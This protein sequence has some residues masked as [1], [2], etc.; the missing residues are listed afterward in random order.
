MSDSIVRLM[1]YDPRWRQEFQQTRSSILFSCQGWVT[2]VEHIGS[3][4]IP[5][6]VAR[7]IIDCIAGVSDSA[8]FESASLLIEGM[9]FRRIDVPKWADECWVLAK[10]RHGETSHL[11]VLAVQDS[12]VWQRAVAVRDYLRARPEEAIRFEETKIRRWRNHEGDPAQYQRDKS[13]FFSH[14]LDQIE[15]TGST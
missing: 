6:L 1:H 9:N 15:S 11:V 12:L 14:L 10:P 3:T 2:A 13:L 4:A 5:G 7:P 8:D